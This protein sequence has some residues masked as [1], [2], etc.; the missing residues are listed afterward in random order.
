MNCSVEIVAQKHSF[1]PTT[2]IIRKY[3]NEDET[4]WL[5][6]RVLSFLDTAYYDSVFREKEKYANESIELVAEED[7]KIIG[8]IDLELEKETG[9]VCSP[10]KGLAAMIWH[11]AVHPDHQRKGTGESLLN[12]AE[13]I[14]NEFGIT[15][16]EAYTRD[17]VRVNDWYRKNGFEM[18]GSYYHIYMVDKDEMKGL[19]RSELPKLFPV[20]TF[21]HYTGDDIDSLRPR[22]KRIHECRC[23]SKNI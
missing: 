10:G 5:R 2:M 13:K 11:I 7:G 6:C 14:C 3:T 22:M 20:H 1:K 15:R 18:I 17:D 8:L 21:A 23:Y 4:G 16:I 19:V 12:E 9:T